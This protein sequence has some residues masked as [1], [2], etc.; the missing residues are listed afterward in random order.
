[1]AAYRIERALREL[2]HRTRGQPAPYSGA[3]SSGNRGAT[4]ERLVTESRL[5]V[6]GDHGWGAIKELSSSQKGPDKI[7]A[8]EYRFDE[9]S[10]LE[11]GT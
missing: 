7:G 1:M 10:A 9:V 6:Q 11:A 5:P 2:R 8:L 3:F 4:A